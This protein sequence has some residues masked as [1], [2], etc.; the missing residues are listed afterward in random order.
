MRLIGIVMAELDWKIW[1]GGLMA[2]RCVNSPGLRHLVSIHLGFLCLLEAVCMHAAEPRVWKTGWASPRLSWKK[3]RC[4]WLQ[5]CLAWGQQLH[6]CRPPDLACGSGTFTTSFFSF[7]ML[8][9]IQILKDRHHI[10]MPPTDC[11]EHLNHERQIEVRYFRVNNLVRY[12]PEE[13]VETKKRATSRVNKGLAS[14]IWQET[15][16]N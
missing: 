8:R 5:S 14:I 1:E 2:T 10:C 15:K 7:Y 12:F 16:F 13:L 4:H 9:G 11:L 3:E 6:L